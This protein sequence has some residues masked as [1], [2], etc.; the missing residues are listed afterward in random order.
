M[1][2]NIRKLVTHDGKFHT[3][4]ALSFHILKTLFPD[5][6]LVRTREERYFSNPERNKI[7][8]DVGLK[9]D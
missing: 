6:S 3:D 5:A 9:Y 7:I 8:F 4:D 1:K 2:N